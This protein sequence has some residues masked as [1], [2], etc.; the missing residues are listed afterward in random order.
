MKL[1]K[2][3]AAY[4]LLS[5]FLFNTMGYFVAFKVAQHQIKSTIISEINAGVSFS[6]ESILIINKKNVSSIIWEENGKEMTYN[7]KR[8]DIIKSIED[9]NAITYYCINDK[10]EETLFANLDEHI[11]TH[12][13]S[14]KPIKNNSQKSLENDVVKIFFTNHQEYKF[15]TTENNNSYFPIKEDYISEYITTNSLPPELV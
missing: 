5:I 1:S 13:I 15:S 9:N 2:K 12:I 4:F 6:E 8:F 14:S 3:I 11:S 10:Q 7:G